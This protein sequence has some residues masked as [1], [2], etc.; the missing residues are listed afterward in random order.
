MSDKMFSNTVSSLL[1]RDPDQGLGNG[2][3]NTSR[4]KSRDKK[5]K[6]RR[7]KSQGGGRNKK[8]TQKIGSVEIPS[9]DVDSGSESDSNNVRVKPS[10]NDPTERKAIDINTLNLTQPWQGELPAA[11][12]AIPQVIPRVR[13]WPYEERMVPIYDSKDLP[14]G[15]VD[16]EDDLDE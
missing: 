11:A 9:V 16:T 3:S 7:S 15:W 6:K 14:A 13:R 1:N 2:N 4:N 10:P 8:N 5:N 12:T